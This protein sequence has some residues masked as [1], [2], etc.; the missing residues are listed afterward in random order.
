MTERLEPVTVDLPLAAPDQHAGTKPRFIWHLRHTAPGLPLDWCL[1]HRDLHLAAPPRNATLHLFAATR[2]RLRVNGAILGS[3]PARYVPGH[4]EYDTFDIT[5]HLKPG[6]NRI[7]VECCFINAN[8]FQSMPEPAG[9]FIAWGRVLC[10]NDEAID[11]ATP[12]D[13]HAEH[14]DAWLPAVPSFSFAVGPVEMLDLR[15]LHTDR[16]LPNDR[17]D[18]SHDSSRVAVMNAPPLTLR[19]RSIGMPDPSAFHTPRLLHAAPLIDREQRLGFVSIDRQASHEDPTTARLKRFRYAAFIHSPIAQSITAGLHWGPHFLNGQPVAAE[20]DAAHGNRQ[21][22]SLSLNPGWNLLCGEPQQLHS[23]YPLLIGLPLDAGL[24]VRAG[25]DENNRHCLRYADPQHLSPGTSWADHPPADEQH[26]AACPIHWHHIPLDTPP[27]CPARM[28]SWDRLDPAPLDPAPALPITLPPSTRQWTAVFDFGEEYLGHVNIDLD[29][30]CGCIVD[31]AYDERL[32]ED[33]SLAFFQSNPFVESAD[34]FICRAGRQSIETF[35][36][37][38]GRYLQITLRRPP[39]DDRPITLHSVRLRSARCLPR[40]TGEFHSDDSLL[41][42]TW[43]TGLAT[44]RASIEDS[45][46]DSPWRER[47][48]YLGD[49]YVQ[50]L[51]LLAAS[52]DHRLARRAL[53]LWAQGQRDDGQ[54]P[55][56]VPAWL[57]LP[58][59]DFTLIYPIWLRDYWA[60][61]GDIQTVRD[62]LPAVQRIRQSPTWFTSRSNLWDATEANRL[63]IDW[64]VAQEARVCDENAVLNALRI[65]GLR[66]TGE[67]LAALHRPDD[68]AIYLRE[69]DDIQ[70]LF[71]QRLW[72]A[73]HHRFAGGTRDDRP[74]K[75]EILHANVLALAYDLPDEQQK[76]H[77]TR[78]VIDRL[79]ENADRAIQPDA[80]R[81]FIELFYLKFAL[82]AM[83]R[84]NRHDIAE[85]IIRQHY[86]VM[87]EHGAW[88]FWEALHRGVQGRDSL[89]HAWSAAAME[90]FSRYVLGVREK[91]PGRPDH[92]IVDPRVVS[93]HQARGVVPHPAGPIHVSWTRRPDGTLAIETSAPPSVELNSCS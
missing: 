53:R 62:C 87:R 43:Q 76:S 74:I 7:A 27:P 17:P 91:T 90:Y 92:L 21:N 19:P 84:A 28:M 66:C 38:G 77:L 40:F 39:G 36:P 54:M 35:H 68:A 9:R 80:P 88:T 58:H 48:T 32:R 14:C 26:L 31:P 12:G 60:R 50:S 3:G 72:L 70:R 57:R 93:I 18:A 61:T 5:S 29:A 89:C 78:Y 30:P 6:D 65:A 45:F 10:D 86:G 85:Q 59:S 56:V 41:N 22:A 15:R 11:L 83:V 63:F 20:Y 25:P 55:G 49:S 33:G 81:G 51:I 52:D 67:L 69:A 82:D 2:Y 75:T 23:C 46:C 71:Q 73:D 13:W 79:L 44:L 42:W 16:F 24:T 64:G 47:G 4:E 1:L 37:R 34:R 8:N